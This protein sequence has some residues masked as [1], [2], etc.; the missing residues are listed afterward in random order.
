MQQPILFFWL[1]MHLLLC[2]SV[3]QQ[4]AEL[5]PHIVL[6]HRAISFSQLSRV[7]LSVDVRVYVCWCF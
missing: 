7:C 6:P 1:K 3:R 4:R 2:A 5:F